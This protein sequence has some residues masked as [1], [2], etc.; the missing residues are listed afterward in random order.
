[1]KVS[2][3]EYVIYRDFGNGYD[4]EVSGA[5]NNKTVNPDITIFVW[6][7]TKEVIE[8]VD[9]KSFQALQEQ[10]SKIEEKYSRLS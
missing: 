10:L 9:I 5:N 6:F 7:K 8:T 3:Y 2:D 1:M 4:L